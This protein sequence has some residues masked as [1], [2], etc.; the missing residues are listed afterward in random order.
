MTRP[1]LKRS[2]WL[3]EI[4]VYLSP[5][6]RYAWVIVVSSHDNPAKS[7]KYSVVVNYK[8]YHD[9]VFLSPSGPI[10]ALWPNFR[11]IGSVTATEIEQIKK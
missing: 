2:G 7:Q 6:G 8:S 3:I 11:P 5:F 4:L 1:F 10:H 9:K